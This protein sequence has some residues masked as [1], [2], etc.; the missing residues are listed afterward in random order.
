MRARRALALAIAVVLCAS[1]VVWSTD[2]AAQQVRPQP[3]A[4]TSPEVH[5]D[6]LAPP[7]P[8]WPLLPMVL[9][10]GAGVAVSAVY[11]LKVGTDQ[12][13]YDHFNAEIL[14]K[15]GTFGSPNG[16]GACQ[17]PTSADVIA[18]CAGLKASQD[19]VNKDN[20]LIV[21]G[22][23]VTGTAVVGGL[24]YYFWGPGKPDR[25]VAGQ[26]AV[27]TPWLGSGASGMSLSGRF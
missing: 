9:L 2:A 3:G 8:I 7:Q 11:A 12:D 17:S 25:R 5:K 18:A 13:S 22:G 21:V 16:T 4:S 20:T 23:I 14:T 27:V 24:L 10:A 19:D 6:W 15:T 1:G 26:A